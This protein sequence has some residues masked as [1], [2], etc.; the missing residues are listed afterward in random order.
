MKIMDIYMGYVHYLLF[1]ALHPFPDGSDRTRLTF[2][3]VKSVI[4]IELM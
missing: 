1:E 4:S 2:F 3:N